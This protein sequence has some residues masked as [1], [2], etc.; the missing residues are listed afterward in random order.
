MSVLRWCSLSWS[1]ALL[2]LLGAPI[3]F[4]IGWK[5]TAGYGATA[6]VAV[7]VGAYW[8]FLDVLAGGDLGERA[9]GRRGL[10]YHVRVRLASRQ[11]R[12]GQ[13]VT[14]DGAAVGL[15]QTGRPV[16]V[17]MCGSRPAHG[18][19]CGATGSGKTVT[20]ILIALAAIMSGFGVIVIDPKPDDF[21]LEQPR[22]A[23]LRAGRRLILWSPNGGTVYNPYEHGS[24]TEIADKLLATETFTEPHCQRLAQRYLGHVVRA[25][26]GAGVAVSVATVVEHMEPGR[27]AS[28][29]R[30]LPAPKASALLDYLGT[31]TP[32]QDA[33]SPGR[34]TG[35]RCSPR[36]T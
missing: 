21:M 24:D 2:L 17:P 28:L 36:P 1:W 15:D 33:I 22:E 5:P 6:T 30:D 18:L 29:A 32:R 3:A 4:L 34:A 31:L 11:I 20:M 19:A 26:R 9:R 35:W 13:W 14:E 16:R 7:V 10:T 12:N 23:V 27:L 25:L 8:H